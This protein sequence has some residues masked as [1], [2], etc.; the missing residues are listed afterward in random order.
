MGLGGAVREGQGFLHSLY[1]QTGPFRVGCYAWG[2]VQKA[3]RPCPLAP[4]GGPQKFL[5]LHPEE[6]VPGRF[7]ARD[8]L[9]L[10][11]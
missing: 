3:S 9:V 6:G 5:E 8:A 2:R 4:G 10:F 7:P 11:S 1:N